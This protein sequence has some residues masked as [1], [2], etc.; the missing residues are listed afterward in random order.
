MLRRCP[1]AK[2]DDL[3]E[4]EEEDK[5]EDVTTEMTTTSKPKPHVMCPHPPF[6]SGFLNPQVH[7]RSVVNMTEIIPGT[8][9]TYT[10]RYQVY[11]G[12]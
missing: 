4:E 11:I 3:K 1:W 8:K 2:K 7:N 10:C 12:K 5:T 9:I 6:V